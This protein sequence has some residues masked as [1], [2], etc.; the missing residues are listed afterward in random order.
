MNLIKIN[1]ITLDNLG[2]SGVPYKVQA[3][4]YAFN[5]YLILFLKKEK[6]V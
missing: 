4:L 6:L 1:R 3:Y 2:E 5:I